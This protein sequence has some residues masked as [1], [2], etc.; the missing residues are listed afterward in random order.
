MNDTRKP[1]ASLDSLVSGAQADVKTFRPDEPKKGS[2]ATKS[3]VAAVALA[4]AAYLLWTQAGPHF[5]GPSEAQV[6]H[7]LTGLAQAARASVEAQKRE[8]G[9]L[10]ETLDDPLLASVVRYERTGDS[11]RL[12]A[13]DGKVSIEMDAGG[14]VTPK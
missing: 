12:H 4:A 5:L 1:D 9:S 7:D 10:P 6:R 8:K 11:Y 3:V 2:G 13:T 14:A